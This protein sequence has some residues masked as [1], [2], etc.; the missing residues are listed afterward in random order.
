MKGYLVAHYVKLYFFLYSRTNYAK[1]YG[2]AFLS[3]KHFHDHIGGLL[4]SCN[5]RVVHA[6]NSVA[7]HNSHFLRRSFVGGLYH[8]QGVFYHVKLHAYSFKV[9]SQ[10]FIECF[11]LRRI[12]VC[13][14]R[15]EL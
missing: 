5:H 10:G 3:A 15:I 11:C 1:V 2:C 6:H 8:H 12:G 14:V 9:A 4:N 13:G 7:C